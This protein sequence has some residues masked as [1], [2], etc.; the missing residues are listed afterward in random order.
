MKFPLKRPISYTLIF[1]LTWQPAL[2]SAGAVVVDATSGENKP[3]LDAALNGVLIINIVKPTAKGV[4]HNKYTQ[5]NIDSQGLILNNGKTLS[6]TDLAGYIQGN[7]NL[8]SG[9]ASIILN[10]VTAANRSQLNGYA[11]IAGQSAEFVLANP[12]GITCSG[13][14]FINTPR[15]TLTTGTANMLDGGL[16]GFSVEGGDITLG[17]F[18]AN[19][20]NRVD[21]LA[22]AIAINGD[23]Q[24]KKINLITGRNDID[25]ATLNPTA[26][27]DD[28][29]TAPAFALD[30][31][32]LGGMY[33]N[34]ITL[35]GTEQG[36]GVNIDSNLVSNAG[37]MVLDIN[38]NLSVGGKLESSQS[39]E[40]TADAIELNAGRIAADTQLM[41]D[42][43]SLSNNG[44]VVVADEAL[45]TIVDTMSSVGGSFV[46]TN[47]TV[48]ARD[49]TNDVDASILIGND[50]EIQINTFS[51]AGLIEAGRNLDLTLLQQGSLDGTN[52]SAS[53]WLTLDARNDFSIGTGS[54]LIGN[55]HLQLTV[56]GDFN[57]DGELS[58][59]GNIWIDAVNLNNDVNA[60]LSAGNDIDLNLSGDLVNYGRISGANDF[61]LNAVNVQNMGS[62]S[63][64]AA[65]QDLSFWLAGNL[66]NEGLL[67][68]GNDANYQLDGDVNNNYGTVFA[69]NDLAFTDLSGSGLLGAFNNVSGVIQS[70]VGDLFIGAANVTNK[71]DQF[72]SGTQTYY[73]QIF[74]YTCAPD[75]KGDG[76]DFG[77]NWT[78]YTLTSVDSS[79]PEA[80]ILSGNDLSIISGDIVNQYSQIYSGHDMV[81]TGT[82]LSNEGYTVGESAV[83]EWRRG[84][85]TDGHYSRVGALV[86][87]FNTKAITF[88]YS[89]VGGT[90]TALRIF[91]AS[92][93]SSLAT[94]NLVSTTTSYTLFEEY[95]GTIQAG[96]SLTG[97]FVGQI[98]NDDIADNATEYTLS[99]KSTNLAA[100]SRDAQVV[101][102]VTELVNLDDFAQSNTGIG[103]VTYQPDPTANYLI[104]S[105][106]LFADFGTF[107]SS[108]Y[109]IGIL[110]IDSESI[111]KRLGD[112]YVETQ[113]INKQLI[114]AQG[115]LQYY[116]NSQDLTSLYQQLMDNAVGSANKLDLSFGL[117]LSA[118]QL[119]RLDDDIVWM[120]EQEVQGQRVLVPILY[121]A[122]TDLSDIQVSGALINGADVN[123]TAGAINSSG[124][125]RSRD[126]L[127]VTATDGDITNRGTLAGQ[128]INATARRN[129]TNRGG[130]I[131]GDT[132]ALTAQAGSVTLETT[133][134][135]T[136]T[137][138]KRQGNADYISTSQGDKAIVQAQQLTVVAGQDINVIAA[139]ITTSENL[140][141][142]AANDINIEAV[143]TRE[144]SALVSKKYTII[145]DTTRHVKSNL[146]AGGDFIA[147]AGQDINLVGSSI[148]AA[149]DAQLT[150]ARDVQVAAVQDKNYSFYKSEKKGSFGRSSSK[151]IEKSSTKQKGS[152]INAGGDVFINA[153]QNDGTFT[154]QDSRD[155]TVTASKLNAG[156]DLVAY[157]GRTLTVQSGENAQSDFYHE[158]KSGFGGLSGSLEEN[159][160]VTTTQ[161]KSELTAGN[162]LILLSA[163]DTNILAS[164]VEAGE[165]IQIN[166]GTDVN[167]MSGTDEEISSHY[168]EDSSLSFSL[169]GASYQKNLIKGDNL[170]R[171]NVAS[172]IK[173]GNE[174]I[175]SA[176][177]SITVLG[178]DLSAANDL[179][180]NAKEQIQIL[181]A[182]Q[183]HQSSYEEDDTGWG[184]STLLDTSF[185]GSYS[186]S[187]L[188]TDDTR[189]TRRSSTLSAG[190]TLA[191]EADSNIIIEAAKLSSG[192]NTN[193]TSNEGSI[194]FL[195][196]TDSES[197][198]EEGK[199]STTV[200]QYQEG[201]GSVDETV[202]HTEIDAGGDINITAKRGVIVQ[203]REGEQGDNLKQ[204]LAKL[205]NE[206]KDLA[207]MAKLQDRDDI[208]WQEIAEAHEQ[209]D[210]ES[211]GL[212][213][214]ASLAIVIV[215]AVLTAGA[216]AAALNGAAATTAG[217]AT[218]GGATV[219]TTVGAGS[220]IVTA[221][222][223]TLSTTVLGSVANAAVTS[224]ATTT[225][226]SL[227]NNK[228]DIGAVLDELGSSE[229]VKKLA[230]AAASAGLGLTDPARSSITLS[231]ITLQAIATVDPEL[232]RLL[233]FAS[234]QWGNEWGKVFNNAIG[235][236]L[237]Y[238]A[239]KE[240][241]RQAE[242]L[243]LT[244]EE[245]NVILMAN[246]FLGREVAGSTYT[247][248]DDEKYYSSVKG[249]FSRDGE[250][251]GGATKYFG[252][253]WD[254]NDSILNA[255]GHL[256]A[257]SQEVVKDGKQ[258]L[259]GHSLGAWRVNNLARR[260]YVDHAVTVSLP[261]FD[262]PVA[263][264]E[265]HCTNLD[266][267]CLGGLGNLL[268][269]G[270]I[271]SESPSW[272]GVVTKNHGLR[273][274]KDYAFTWEFYT[275][276]PIYG[277]E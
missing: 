176:D 101:D 139:D 82:S 234:G 124:A 156:N 11:E 57:N 197:H 173:A 116:N 66:N 240:V 166:A 202:K 215:V 226:L 28:G 232:S 268:R 256:D 190:K 219:A 274:V 212:T 267:I 208:D 179:T 88:D 243:G 91:N 225:T 149:G 223:A 231:D 59:A 224:L 195:T 251:L 220:T 115:S 213:E 157:A 186:E 252:G 26:K 184:T 170:D 221:T 126:T 65:G 129:L 248:S 228:G 227:A 112:G 77:G 125:L 39:I 108:D 275:G 235:E 15:A 63:S 32:A 152:L 89:T 261:L 70:F 44:G 119:S 121:L 229:N 144:R 194:A 188:K 168:K 48:N 273:T 24:A 30:V 29:S 160:T 192:E 38:G 183:V 109:M 46:A 3:T 270:T 102:G 141:F 94:T 127:R 45:L 148:D 263:G 17:D 7:P 43:N 73:S 41:V 37:G 23:I 105:N 191:L 100:A 64:L 189:V 142:Y 117:A 169:L 58:S 247:K 137:G 165:N 216:G 86:S 196:A 277:Q 72:T 103:G 93:P 174:L 233:G 253:F 56:A 90:G 14:G 52:L 193:I 276:K 13:C 67:F 239:R 18:N 6:K 4:S 269:G 81:L 35:I 161:V 180:L 171:T 159:R 181:S 9:S 130:H 158:E 164:T 51:G 258:N 74:N 80:Q 120:V 96:N 47:A 25:Y 19:N 205:S 266:G 55:N 154:A 5:F 254:I 167:I 62:G 53:N 8:T 155:V 69:G 122:N 95:R 187:E 146:N 153:L 245:L 21:V 236:T 71:R 257:I 133:I 209:W 12:Y 250:A 206:N 163:N 131:L 68:A 264:T 123:L 114:A 217:T 162:D 97:S 1:V 128:Y 34:Q 265:S 177:K 147:S 104:E 185:T 199:G 33:A 201:E 272:L 54:S 76:Y 106:P 140:E 178:S 75:C 210:Y 211:E 249:F 134:Q 241:A 244:L 132:V 20:V 136:H 111:M 2:V 222:G 50:L 36:V 262:Y 150:A 22:R 237:Q 145:K 255:Q 218:V 172:Q 110:N 49:I 61:Y 42:A 60:T 16:T 113:F 238:E 118:E 242:K 78:K 260:G 204:A 214:I 246:S 175:I 271:S 99:A 27:V 138:T 84:H 182:T 92:L 40:L 198:S 143:E 230:L 151:T 79:N 85:S 259:I 10:E 107:I 98:N 31:A 203:Y 135:Q 207:W 83:W 200:W 87:A